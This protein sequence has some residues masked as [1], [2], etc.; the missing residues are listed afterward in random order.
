M[1]HW[2]IFPSQAGLLVYAALPAERCEATGL[3]ELPGCLWQVVVGRHVTLASRV[4]GIGGY[5]WRQRHAADWLVL[6]PRF[7]MVLCM[8]AFNFDLRAA[9]I[10]SK[11][12]RF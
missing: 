9:L 3:A 1:L 8:V 12:S 2:A 6:H 5:F 11:T 4:R 10:K 7:F